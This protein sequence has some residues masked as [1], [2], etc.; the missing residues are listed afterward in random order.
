MVNNFKADFENANSHLKGEFNAI[1]KNF[2]MFEGGA[3][4]T[5][6]AVAAAAASSK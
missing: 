6:P 5:A 3:P 4:S 1:F 2:R